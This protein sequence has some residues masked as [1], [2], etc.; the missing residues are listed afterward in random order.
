MATIE[1]RGQIIDK[2]TGNGIASCQ[3]E[4]WTFINE[5]QA[6]SEISAETLADGSFLI[7]AQIDRVKDSN[8]FFYLKIKQNE[9]LLTESELINA[10]NALDSV[11]HLRIEVMSTSVTGNMRV[12]GL[13]KSADGNPQIGLRVIAYD[14]TTPRQN[15]IRTR[16]GFLN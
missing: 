10:N 9:V 13:V 6:N 16:T 8:Y 12:Y 4:L 14:K 1:I 3:I 7:T 2:L 11:S 5:T 15:D